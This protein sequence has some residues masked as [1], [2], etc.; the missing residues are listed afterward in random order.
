MLLTS[1][2]CK[3]LNTSC[4]IIEVVERKSDCKLF[5]TRV[6]VE[7]KHHEEMHLFS[8]QYADHTTY[9]L[10]EDEEGAIDQ[11]SCAVPIVCDMNVRKDV[12]CVQLPIMLR[13]WSNRQF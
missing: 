10:A 4:S 11:A 13:G 9:V 2:E 6:D 3:P 12:I 8:V 5:L 1:T 7:T